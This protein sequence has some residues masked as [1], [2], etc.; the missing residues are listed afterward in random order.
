MYRAAA[1]VFLSV[2]LAGSLA[3]CSNTNDGWSDAELTSIESL[4]LTN[5]PAL[6]RDPSNRVADNPAAAAL[7][8][9]LFFDTRLS[10]N[11]EVA[12]ATCHQPDKQFQDGTPLATGMGTTDRRTMIIAGTAYS[13]WFFWDGRKDSQWA[14]ALGPL[15]SPVEHGTDRA[16]VAHLI[17]THYRGEYEAVFGALPD[18]SAV[19]P[20]ASPLGSEVVL[21]AWNSMPAESTTAVDRVFANAGK[22]IAAF[23]RTI[24]PGRARFDRYADALAG[25]DDAAA[26]LTAEE[27]LGLKLFIGRAN[28][29]NCHNGPLFTDNHFHNTGVPAVDGLPED[30]GRASGVAKVTADP[31]NCL[32]PY[33][34]AK[35][36]DC[37]ELKYMQKTGEELVRAYKPGSLR[38]I[39]GR[40]PFMHAG[41]FASLAEVVD[42]YNLAPAAPVGHSE[43]VPLNLSEQEKGAIV[44]FLKTLEAED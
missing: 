6:P 9:A 34:D 7:G 41:Q 29:L 26:M 21:S 17:A 40:A 35:T 18:V 11:G 4:S 44:A 14:Q 42:H 24:M 8:K 33:S 22:A 13:P 36:S 31:F 20:H 5:L 39:A 12:C 38:G 19:P 15:E 28:C 3:S 43:L 30:L 10:A 37:A 23:E 1:A 32:G 2:V 25:G 27:R 16:A